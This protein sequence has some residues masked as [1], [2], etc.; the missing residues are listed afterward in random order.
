MAVFIKVENKLELAQRDIYVLRKSQQETL[1]EHRVCYPYGESE[2]ENPAVR[3]P[4]GTAAEQEYLEISVDKDQVA[5]DPCKIDL[6]ANVP[7]TF[8]PAGTE[9][10]TVVPANNGIN[11]VSLKIPPGLPKWK[12]EIMEPLASAQSTGP[13]LLDME[14]KQWNGESSPNEPNVTVGDDGTGGD[15]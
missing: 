6:P 4:L 1:D 3:L 12:L 5:L 14:N 9:S 13:D 8:I 15:G 11:K 2:E 10:I 7:F